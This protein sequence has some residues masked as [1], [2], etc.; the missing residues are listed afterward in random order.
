MTVG[1]GDRAAVLAGHEAADV[2]H[3]QA[4]Q[5]ADAMRQEGRGHALREHR[6]LV[7]PH[8]AQ[9][10]QHAGDLAVRGQVDVAV[11]DARAHAIDQAQLRG[12]HRVDQRL[13][14]G[15]AVAGG[16]GDVR[17]ITAAVR[18]RVD[19]QRQRLRRRL[20]VLVLVMQHRGVLVQRDDVAV[21]QIALGQTAGLE[22]GGMDR[23]LRPAF[24]EG[25]LRGQMR[26]RAQR[27]CLA[28]ALQLVAGLHRARVM[29][30]VQHLGRVIR[31]D[32]AQRRVGLA[33]DRQLARQLQVGQR[34]T[35]GAHHDQFEVLH[36]ET[37]RCLGR[38]MPVVL[39][40]DVDQPGPVAGTDHQPAVR[41]ADQRHPQLEVGVGLEDVGPV[42]EEG[43]LLDTGRDQQRVVATALERVFGAALLLGEVGHI[44]RIQRIR[45]VGALAVGGIDGIHARGFSQTTPISVSIASSRTSFGWAVSVGWKPWLKPT[46]TACG[47]GWI[48]AMVRSMKPPP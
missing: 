28:Q 1:L 37:A 46:P 36:P 22:V 18:A 8:D 35:R 7:H 32:V 31:D 24:A 47:R 2:V 45:R 44:Q 16:A 10:P 30:G 41:M 27:R 5:V 14:A 9:L 12:L 42:V 19:Q 34:V 13:E 15:V 23:R 20:L 48:C 38:H 17:G 21:G 29:Q 33:D 39:G 25:A 3:L 4:E 40:L 11:V 6:V 26:R 43:E